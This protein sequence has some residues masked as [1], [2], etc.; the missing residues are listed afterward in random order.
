MLGHIEAAPIGGPPGGCDA[1]LGFPV[2]GQEVERR[3]RDRWGQAPPPSPSPTIHA[4][5]ACIC[6]WGTNV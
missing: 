2:R 4:R 6:R 5:A 3:V 1:P